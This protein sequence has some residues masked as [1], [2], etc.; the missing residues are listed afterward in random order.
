MSKCGSVDSLYGEVASRLGLRI[1]GPPPASR[2]CGRILSYVVE[3]ARKLNLPEDVVG[4]AERVALELS[5]RG[6]RVRDSR[7]VAAAVLYL[8]CRLKGYTMPSRYIVHVANQMGWALEHVSVRRKYREVVRYLGITPPPQSREQARQAIRLYHELVKPAT[9][10]EAE[11]EEAGQAEEGVARQAQEQPPTPP[12]T[13]Y[14]RGVAEKLGLPDRVVEDAINMVE[15]IG[16]T[17]AP[18]VSGAI[19]LSC[20]KHNVEIHTADLEGDYYTGARILIEALG[21]ANARSFLAVRAYKR[22]IAWAEAGRVRIGAGYERRVRT[23][24]GVVELLWSEF[25]NAFPVA[26]VMMATRVLDELVK[27]G[28]AT[29]RYD[30]HRSRKLITIDLNKLKTLLEQLEGKHVAKG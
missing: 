22:I 15:R 29:V 27:M 18:V 2:V 21:L 8:A 9:A 5:I 16:V 4:E 30:R 1:R 25:M 11:R 26:P 24:G 10:S 12:H 3:L 28:I 13:A 23:E 14:I 19:Y 7:V 6:F 20:L 17:W